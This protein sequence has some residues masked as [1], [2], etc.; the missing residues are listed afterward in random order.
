MSAVIY[1]IGTNEITEATLIAIAA[2]IGLFFALFEVRRSI[3]ISCSH[4]DISILAE[5]NKWSF[6]YNKYNDFIHAGRVINVLEMIAKTAM[7]GIYPYKEYKSSY[8]PVT[9]VYLYN[10]ELAY[11][12]EKK[13]NR[14]N[15]EK[16]VKDFL[17]VLMPVFEIYKAW[18]KKEV[19][20]SDLTY[21]NLKHIDPHTHTLSKS[22]SRSL[23]YK[24]KYPR[25]YEKLSRT[26]NFLGPVFTRP[27]KKE[28]G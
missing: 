15:F 9:F 13:G 3:K 22:D 26:I 8:F 21:D 25:L 11:Y 20:S 1:T 27:S 18:V 23:K 14:K 7:R 28:K 24:M 16:Y 6:E 10:L 5:Y 4:A 2:V 17:Q 12:K 19:K